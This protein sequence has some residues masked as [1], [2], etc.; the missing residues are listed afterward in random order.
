M[1]FLAR[2]LHS[3][4]FFFSQPCSMK[5]EGLCFWHD[6]P[7]FLLYLWCSQRLSK[8]GSGK[9]TVTGGKTWQFLRPIGVWRKQ[10][11]EV[12]GLVQAHGWSQILMIVTDC[13]G[14]FMFF[15]QP[16][17][18]GVW[19]CLGVRFPFSLRRKKDLSSLWDELDPFSGSRAYP[20]RTDQW[21]RTNKKLLWLVVWNIFYFPI[22]WE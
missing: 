6:S 5:P 21:T 10:R 17:T 19:W 15:L 1:I 13:C 20:S 7:M 22:Y 16:V 2:N 18:R 12:W 11:W 14:S 8:V 9:L 3:V 4:P